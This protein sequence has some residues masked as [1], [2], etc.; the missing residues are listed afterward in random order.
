MRKFLLT[1]LTAIS[2]MFSGCSYN[3]SDLW[4]AVDDL[5]SRVEALEAATRSI[6]SDIEALQAMVNAL[7][8]NVSVTQVEQTSNGYV[9]HFSDGSQ[10]TIANGRD[11]ENGV[12]AP[13]I[14]VKQD[15]DGNYYWTKG[16]EWLVVN[17]QK[18]RANAIDGKDGESAIAPQVRINPDTKEWEISVDNGETWTGTGVIAQPKDENPSLFK[19]V[20][21][22]DDCVIFTMTDGSVFTLMRN[23][24]IF[25]EVRDGSGKDISVRTVEFAAGQSRSFQVISSTILS[26]TIAAP[27]GWEI[28][29]A[30][31]VLTVVAPATAPANEAEVKINLTFPSSSRALQMVTSAVYTFKVAV[32]Y[33][34]RVLTFEDADV[35][36][37]EFTLYRGGEQ[38]IAK[39]SDLIDD[40]QYGGP[41]LY[42]DYD[43]SSPY[44]WYDTNN[45]EL[46]HVFPEGYGSY[47]Y[48]SGG[49]AISNYADDDVETTGNYVYQLTIPGTQ[50]RA[51]H[52]GSSNFAV[53]FGYIDDSGFSMTFELPSLEFGDG[54]ERVIDHM[55][56]IPNNYALYTYVNGNSLSSK[57]G[58]DDYVKI[59]AI[60]YDGNGKKT[61]ETNITLAHG[62]ELI[63]KWTQWDLSVLGKVQKIEFNILGTNDNG[64]GFS[65][66]AYFAYDDVAVRFPL[67]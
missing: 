47:I 43:G 1:M 23:D 24:G 10:A 31:D 65:Q 8:S 52:N 19:N 58:D 26:Y 38:S 32:T 62:T 63:S 42:D 28:T 18:V 64:Y 54:I 27:Q 13:E 34:L 35:K 50:G 51:G 9:I 11:G 41:L 55:W 57:L 56:V 15:T 53:H 5:T 59:I 2:F 66:P 39:W 3:D 30:D 33:E 25:F 45:T 49:H 44:W 16:G 61:G 22:T 37:E 12:N 6:N 36:F 40:S 21:V 29:L 46:M 20:E 17:G 60:G 67:N 7:Q 4:E 48:W 14:S